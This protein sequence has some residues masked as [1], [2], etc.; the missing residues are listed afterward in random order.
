MA[1]YGV[2]S[3]VGKLGKVLVHRPNRSLKRLTCYMSMSIAGEFTH[4]RVA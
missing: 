3:E 2:Y 4:G 1:T